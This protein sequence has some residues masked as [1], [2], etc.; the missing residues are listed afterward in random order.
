MVVVRCSLFCSLAGPEALAEQEAEADA[1]GFHQ[2]IGDARIARRQEEL[3]GLQESGKGESETQDE[4]DRTN[5]GLWTEQQGQQYT[6]GEHLYQL[7][8][9]LVERVQII[10]LKVIR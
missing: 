10:P 3:A 1:Q 2:H 9:H 6:D 8:K 4:E 7:G 5:A